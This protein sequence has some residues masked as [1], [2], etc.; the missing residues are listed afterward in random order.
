[1]DH[2]DTPAEPGEKPGFLASARA[3]EVERLGLLPR[4]LLISDGTLTDIVETA[5]LEPVQLV[6]LT[7]DIAPAQ[8]PI[9][10]LSLAAGDPVMHREILLR[11][12]RTGLNYVFAEVWIALAALPPKLRDDLVNTA[13]PLGRLWVHH[14]LETRKEILNVWRIP[15][16]EEPVDFFN[17]SA[18]SGLL[19]RSYR[20]FSAGLPIMLITEY[21]PADLAPAASSPMPRESV[22]D[23]P[24]PPRLEPCPYR[25]TVESNG[26]TIAATTRAWRV[27]ETSHPPTYYI[28]QDDIRMEFLAANSKHTYCEFKGTATYWDLCLP[29]RAV[30]DAA[31]SYPSPSHAFAPLRDH[32]AFYPNRVDACFVNGERVRPQEGGFYGGWITANLEGPFKGGPGSRGW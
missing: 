13:I 30:S 20:V 15:H 29:G 23:Y 19:A 2:L 7:L 27:L 28:P 10:P 25:I 1:M 21:F 4:I 14:R 16:G 22:W 12:R 11:G 31:W 8:R 17:S 26:E 9:E 18:R 3:V 5:F 6:K 24:R 32:L